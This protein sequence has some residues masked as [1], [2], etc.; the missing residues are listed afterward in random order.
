MYKNIS[1]EIK[2]YRLDDPGFHQLHKKGEEKVI[3][4]WMLQVN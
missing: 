3:L 2:K 1:A 4:A